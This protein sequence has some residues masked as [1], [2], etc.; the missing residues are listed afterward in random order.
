MNEDGSS[1][2]TSATGDESTD[3][4]DPP[5]PCVFVDDFDGDELDTRVWST[6]V[7][8]AASSIEQANGLLQFVLA[9]NGGNAAAYTSL[10]DIHDLAITGVL[11]HV[12]PAQSGI[13][14]DLMLE[15]GGISLRLSVFEGRA[16]VALWDGSWA[17]LAQG[18]V[19]IVSG[20]ELRFTHL[21]G[22]V[23]AEHYST[24]EDEWIS[25][26]TNETPLDLE[27]VTLRLRALGSASQTGHPSYA[28]VSA[29]PSP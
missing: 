2:D 11:G 8:N 1:N 26:W 12:A 29:C 25:L 23:V 7:N 28:S 14:Q 6:Y 19:D 3:T 4:G 17:T 15:N 13:E 22:D 27:G 20:D 9:Q 10:G 16:R 5:L 18:E 24:L 21:N